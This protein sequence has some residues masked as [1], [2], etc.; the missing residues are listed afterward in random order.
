[1]EI[2]E[3]LFRLHLEPDAEGVTSATPP[4][5]AEETVLESGKG[6]AEGSAL[7]G[8]LRYSRRVQRRPGGVATVVFHALVTAEDGPQVVLEGEGREGAT[9]EGVMLLGWT[10]QAA[11]YLAFNGAVL[12]G[13]IEAET[14]T[15]SAASATAP[16]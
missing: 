5:T 14:I 12:V 13:R 7:A 6:R 16:A 9:G 3:P 2:E 15:V 4:G 1:M 8:A 11:R 10:A